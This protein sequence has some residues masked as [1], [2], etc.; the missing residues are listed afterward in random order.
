M[1]VKWSLVCNE[2]YPLL[3]PI[4]AISEHLRLFGVILCIIVEDPTVTVK[5]RTAIQSMFPLHEFVSKCK[6][7]VSHVHL[8]P[9]PFLLQAVPTMRE[10]KSFPN[11]RVKWSLVCNERYPLLLPI[12]AI[13]EHLRLFGVILCILFNILY[14]RF[15]S[16]YP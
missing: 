11:M 1:R 13:S 8:H 6:V 3:L 15:R 5:C 16:K 7:G 9:Y 2:R 10:K 12:N 14:I 4:N